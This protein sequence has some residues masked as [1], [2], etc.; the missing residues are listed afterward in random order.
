MKVSLFGFILRIAKE[1]NYAEAY[2]T[3]NNN[4]FNY[5]FII[6]ILIFFLLTITAAATQW[7]CYFFLILT[8]SMN[9]SVQFDFLCGARLYCSDIM[10][11]QSSGI[12]SAGAWQSPTSIVL[13]F[14]LVFDYTLGKH[15]CCKAN[16]SLLTWLYGICYI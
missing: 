2:V 6:I 12:F 14:S 11:V 10:L 5:Q 13:W 4:W 16:L 1:R 3:N 9:S 7:Q 15:S 8:V